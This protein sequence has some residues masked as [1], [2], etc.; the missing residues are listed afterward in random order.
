MQ[1]ALLSL[2]IILHVQRNTH[3]T[4]ANTSSR[5]TTVIVTCLFSMSYLRGAPC[6]C[7]PRRVRDEN[8]CL[9]AFT[10]VCIIMHVSPMNAPA[11]PNSKVAS[12]HRTASMPDARFR[13]WGKSA[14]PAD[15]ANWA[16]RSRQVYTGI[17]TGA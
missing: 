11:S 17:E 8:H 12:L 15:R 9:D 13:P 1:G 6:Y 10:V 7:N 3:N 16:A 4:A 5:F 14:P 2:G